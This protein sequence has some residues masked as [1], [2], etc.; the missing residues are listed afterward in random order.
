MQKLYL[1]HTHAKNDPVWLEKSDYV[2][3]KTKV[4]P[5]FLG[6]SSKTIPTHRLLFSILMTNLINS[7][8]LDH[9][10]S[11]MFDTLAEFVMHNFIKMAKQ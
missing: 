10:M 5:P 1:I 2:K 4:F 7:K 11:R 3:W 6:N 8:M 9:V